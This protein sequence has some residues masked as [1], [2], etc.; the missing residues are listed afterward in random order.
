MASTLPPQRTDNTRSSPHSKTH[1]DK[2]LRADLVSSRHENDPLVTD[3]FE[4]KIRAAINANPYL[5]GRQLRFEA[6]N[7]RIVL[8]GVVA[9]W[10][11]KQ[12]AQE[13]LRDVAGTAEINNELVVQ[14]GA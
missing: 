14:W 3:E 11:Q 10:F 4:K 13:A 5:A 7:G 9:S 1:G 12:M 8:R 6:A 2:R